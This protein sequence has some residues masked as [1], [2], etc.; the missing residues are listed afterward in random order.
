MDW[1]PIETAPTAEGQEFVAYR[2]GFLAYDTSDEAG[3]LSGCDQGPD[4]FEKTIENEYVTLVVHEGRWLAHDG[5]IYKLN[6]V[7][8]NMD[9]GEC[10]AKC[11]GNCL[12]LRG[13]PPYPSLPK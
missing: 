13:W 3:F 12:A 7:S 10:D 1:Q 6:G 2:S 5:D 8:A 9:C 11:S 4:Y